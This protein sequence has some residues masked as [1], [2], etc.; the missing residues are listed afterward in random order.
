MSTPEEQPQIPPPA[1][2]AP[3][4][5]GPIAAGGIG[6][7]SQAW[8]KVDDLVT[9]AQISG[10]IKAISKLLSTAQGE[11]GVRDAMLASRQQL[12]TE[13]GDALSTAQAVIGELEKKIAALELPV[14]EGE[15]VAPVPANDNT[16]E[17]PPG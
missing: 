7:L 10:G 3:D 17:A 9:A 6:L 13:L 4:P 16:A 14:Q 8:N 15:I 1:P 11:I 5:F 2:P 12:I